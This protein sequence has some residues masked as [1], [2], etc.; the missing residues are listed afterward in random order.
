MRRAPSHRQ[1]PSAARLRSPSRNPPFRAIIALPIMPGPLFGQL[2]RQL[3]Q[4]PTNFVAGGGGNACPRY[5]SYKPRPAIHSRALERLPSVRFEHDALAWPPAP[6]IHL[7]A[8]PGRKLLL[9]I[10]R[11]TLRPEIDVAL[12]APDSPS[13][14]ESAANLTPLITD[15]KK[16]TE[17]VAE[18][19]PVTSVRCQ[20]KRC[21]RSGG[22]R[23]VLHI[24]GRTYCPK[25]PK[26]LLSGK[27]RLIRLNISRTSKKRWIRIL[28]QK[29]AIVSAPWF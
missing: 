29:R 7:V 25:T 5:C 15:S 3:R 21:R 14:A 2:S 20:S 16:F 27:C 1:T 9:V 4:V 6:R 26:A 12:R 18:I 11:V 17:R 19:A 24:R 23:P 22:R 13:S 8:K 28:H 10:I